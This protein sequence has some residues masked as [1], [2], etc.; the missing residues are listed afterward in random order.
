MSL[1]WGP[2]E[3][4][5]DPNFMGPN[6]II[7]ILRHSRGAPADLLND[8]KTISHSRGALTHY[9]DDPKTLRH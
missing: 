2:T 4:L 5:D 7:R 9:L 1:T 3:F 8:P 6:L